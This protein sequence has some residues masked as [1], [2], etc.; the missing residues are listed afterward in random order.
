VEEASL[1]TIELPSAYQGNHFQRIAV[2][3]GLL[4]PAMPRQNFEVQLHRDRA[5]L[6]LEEF[7]R[8][9]HRRTLRQATW[10]PVELDR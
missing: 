9:G 4:A 3:Q 10:L 1:G 5:I 6:Q 7:Q 8:I 2:S